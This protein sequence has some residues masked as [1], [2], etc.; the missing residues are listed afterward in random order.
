MKTAAL[1]KATAAVLTAAAASSGAEAVS[2]GWV[3]ASDRFGGGGGEM[4]IV[5]SIVETASIMLFSVAII[6]GTVL[7]AAVVI[8]AAEIGQDMLSFLWSFFR[9]R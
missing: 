1:F 4:S 3:P 2:I 8:K 6:F 9:R 5:E 7:T